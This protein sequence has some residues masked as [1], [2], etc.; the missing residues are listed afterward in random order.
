[1]GCNS[2]KNKVHIVGAAP[3]S[4]PKLRS[5]ANDNSPH[6][7]SKRNKKAMGSQ[8]SLGGMSNASERLGSGSSKVS[9]RTMDSG[10]D[11]HDNVITEHSD[12]NMVRQVEE[13]F[14]E[15]GDGLGESR[16][17]IVYFY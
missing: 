10:F 7:L 3:T 9:K 2:S 5:G 1:M 8:D 4:E 17:V 15:P 11:D 12:P 14:N 16:D 6:K 13:G